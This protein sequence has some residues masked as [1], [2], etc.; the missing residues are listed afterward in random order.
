[1]DT[2]MLS[3]SPS[4]L[5]ESMINHALVC[6]SWS[7]IVH[8]PLFRR[9]AKSSDVNKA[10]TVK[11]KAKAKAMTSRPRPWRQGQGHSIKAKVKA[12]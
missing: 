5:N 3:E 11:A 4:S 7:E 2:A 6:R 10:S 1:M 8:Q 12:D 9:E